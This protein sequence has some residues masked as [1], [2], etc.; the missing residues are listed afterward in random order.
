MQADFECTE[1]NAILI[2]L[3]WVKQSKLDQAIICDSV[4]SYVV[5]S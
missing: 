1:L 4:S 3:E 5:S 2:G